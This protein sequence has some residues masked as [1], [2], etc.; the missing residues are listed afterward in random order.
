MT[1][2]KPYLHLYCS[3]V[4]VIVLKHVGEKCGVVRHA[5]TPLHMHRLAREQS[6]AHA[7]VQQEQSDAEPKQDPHGSHPELSPDDSGGS[8]G[9]RSH[10]R[11]TST[12]IYMNT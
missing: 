11:D 12:D 8:P 2:T 9:Y 6:V 5:M 10:Q 7:R 4:L 3:D 1:F